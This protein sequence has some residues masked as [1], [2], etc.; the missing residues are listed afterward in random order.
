MQDLI[1][2]LPQ[3]TDTYSASTLPEAIASYAELF[4]FLAV[5]FQLP[6]CHT[7]VHCSQI[8]VT[9]EHEYAHVACHPAGVIVAQPL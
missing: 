1:S 4:S 6:C 3:V 8:N 2:F 5:T 9:A 7:T